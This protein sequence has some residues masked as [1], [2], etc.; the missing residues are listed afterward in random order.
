MDASIINK[1]IN[2]FDTKDHKEVLSLL[3]SIGLNHVMANSEINLLNT[4]LAVLHISQ[5]SISELKDYVKA[6]KT[7]FRD[8]ILWAV[9]SGGFKQSP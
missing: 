6:A 5:G 9:E 2:D 1:V 4:R 7:D 3:S 8:V